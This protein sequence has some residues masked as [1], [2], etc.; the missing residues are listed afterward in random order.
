MSLYPER[1]VNVGREELREALFN[2]IE[3]VT[4]HPLQNSGRKLVL[5]YF[6]DCKDGSGYDRALYAINKYF[7]ES[8]P[9]E[10]TWSKGLRK[11]MEE[12]KKSA[13]AW[14]NEDE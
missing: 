6:N 11:A 1:E 14:D 3:R 13:D 12:L 5:H 9:D 8:L 4:S 7:P 2:V 10:D